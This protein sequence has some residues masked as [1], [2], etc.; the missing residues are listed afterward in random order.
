MIGETY[1]NVRASPLPPSFVL[2]CPIYFHVHKENPFTHVTASQNIV[3]VFALCSKFLL[4]NVKNERKCF[5]ISFSQGKPWFFSLGL[6]TDWR[7]PTHIRKANL[8]YL[9]SIDANANSSKITFTVTPRLV[10]GQ[11]SGHLSHVSLTHNMNHPKGSSWNLRIFAE[12]QSK[13]NRPWQ[14]CI[15]WRG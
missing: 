5:C 14:C 11:I 12:T 3:I 7:K 2:G 4:R 13:G 10:S 1:H 6:S 8:L 15:K 9:K